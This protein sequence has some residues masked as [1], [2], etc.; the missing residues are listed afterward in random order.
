MDRQIDGSIDRWIDGMMTGGWIDKWIDGR[1]WM[2]TSMDQLMNGSIDEQIDGLTDQSMDRWLNQSMDGWMFSAS[3]RGHSAF[4]AVYTNGG[5][6][7]RLVHGSVKHKLQWAT[8]PEQLPFDP[9]LVTLAEGLKETV[10]PYTFVSR[11]GFKEMLEV[12]GANVKVIP[13]LPKV[14]MAIRAALGHTDPSVFEA[15]LDSLIHLSDVVG[16]ELNPYLKN[17]LVPVSKRM[18]DKKFRDKVTEAV[19]K[20]EQ[21]GGQESLPIIKSKIPTYSTIFT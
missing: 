9:V 2:H 1:I 4:A 21:N 11:T 7:C 6:P 18:M 16:P 8:P 17:L 15:G 3:G 19:Q 10:H 14:T 12:N 13:V 5:V 20:M